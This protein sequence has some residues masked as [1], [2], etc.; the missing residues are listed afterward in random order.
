MTFYVMGPLLRYRYKQSLLIV[1][2]YFETG[3]TVRKIFSLYFIRC[4]LHQIIWVLFKVKESGFT[5]WGTNT[6]IEP[7]KSPSEKKGL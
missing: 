4:I 3:T 1:R 7:F 6:Q 2:F 5:D